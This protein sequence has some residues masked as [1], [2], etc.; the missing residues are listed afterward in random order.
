MA[1]AHNSDWSR[2]ASSS[3]VRMF[4]CLIPQFYNPQHAGLPN[5]R[6]PRKTHWPHSRGREDTRINGEILHVVSDECTNFLKTPTCCCHELAHSQGGLPKNGCRDSGARRISK[7]EMASLFENKMRSVRGLYITTGQY[8]SF[9]VS[10]V[11][12]TLGC[13][14]MDTLKMECRAENR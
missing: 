3:K 9:C 8:S 6:A 13:V 1:T 14:D 12:L 2:G 4:S 11:V 5:K 7:N 10:A